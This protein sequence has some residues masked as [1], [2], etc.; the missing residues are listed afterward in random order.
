MSFD[1]P[2]PTQH[3]S[4]RLES[5]LKKYPKSK[6]SIEEA[7]NIKTP[8]H[9]LKNKLRFHPFRKLKIPLKEYKITTSR[10]LRLIYIIA[11][12]KIWLITIYSKSETNKKQ[13]I[14]RLIATGWK[15]IDFSQ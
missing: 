10:G 5:L 4:R 8:D 12:K 6:T 13:E 11:H 15:E 9:T 1:F 7:I 3:Y 14:N 2:L